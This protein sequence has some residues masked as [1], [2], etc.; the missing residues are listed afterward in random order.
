MKL[1][2]NIDYRTNWG[3]SL[4]IAG[5]AADGSTAPFDIKMIMNGSEHWT[6]T[7]EI[8][9]ECIS[10]EY[11]YEVR[12]ENGSVKHEWG[13]PHVFRRGRSARIYNIYDRWQDQP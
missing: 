12:H 5:H 10:L 3:E 4:Y 9:D 1:T 7:V 2:F 13:T 8:P 6:A 11:S